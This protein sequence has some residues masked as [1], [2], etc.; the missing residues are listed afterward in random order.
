MSTRIYI[1][2]DSHKETD[3][4]I[5]ILKKY[6]KDN[7]CELTAKGYY[8]FRQELVWMTLTKYYT[9]S[10]GRPSDML[11]AGHE[12]EELLEP[13]FELCYNYKLSFIYYI[14]QT[15][16]FYHFIDI[17]N[18]LLTITEGNFFIGHEDGMEYLVRRENEGI[19]YISKKYF[20]PAF[21]ELTV[22]FEV[23]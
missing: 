1:G 7:Q 2:F 13:D 5:D 14:S 17:I 21:N 18:E 20:Q 15:P 22:P 12:M 19:I 11:I 3:Y 4:F 16:N 9:L 10:D 6:T 23:V 8:K